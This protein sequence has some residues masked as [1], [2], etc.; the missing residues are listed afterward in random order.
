MKPTDKQIKKL[1][2]WC[3]IKPLY[4]SGE[5]WIDDTR[6]VVANKGNEPPS[7]N[8]NNLFKHAAPRILRMDYDIRLYSAVN[9]YFAQIL[10]ERIDLVPVAESI[11]GTDD[12]AL[13]LFWAIY[14]V[15]K[16]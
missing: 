3:G 7:I 4:P 8:L 12:P 15:I 9:Q 13:A 16:K 14:K 11:Y 5:I 2:G 6:T 10:Q 1:W